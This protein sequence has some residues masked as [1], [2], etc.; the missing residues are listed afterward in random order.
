MYLCADC[1]WLLKPWVRR[2]LVKRDNLV[3]AR[4]VL[5]RR[6]LA[7]GIPVEEVEISA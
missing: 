2:A 6:Q 7:S 1:W 4:L 5:L 3:S